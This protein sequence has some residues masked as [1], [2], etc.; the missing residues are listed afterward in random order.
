MND[1]ENNEEIRWYRSSTKELLFYPLL[2]SML[3][4]ELGLFWIWIASNEPL[5]SFNFA[6]LCL[7]GGLLA[8]YF[9]CIIVM[10]RRRILF[11]IGV[12]S[13]GIYFKYP[14]YMERIRWKNIEKIV[15]VEIL[16]WE[17]K[18]DGQLF[19]NKQ[20]KGYGLVT[21]TRVITI[22][23]SLWKNKKD[24]EEILKAYEQQKVMR[25]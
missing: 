21:S 3:I 2:G 10:Y 11:A 19:S 23:N 25:E 13:S 22:P 7:C 6:I 20:T 4:L 15:P 16:K 5:F 18:W 17:G 9:L 24:V 1:I 14:T 12:S 8:G